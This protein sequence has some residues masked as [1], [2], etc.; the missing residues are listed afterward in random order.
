MAPEGAA[1]SHPPLMLT[2][3]APA[4]ATGNSLQIVIAFF[5]QANVHLNWE[6]LNELVMTH[7][8]SAHRLST[9]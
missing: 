2:Q 9:R 4:T 6:K 1:A 5:I 7:N 8:K 3:A